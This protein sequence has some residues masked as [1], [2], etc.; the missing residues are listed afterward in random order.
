MVH[1]AAHTA[2]Q[3]LPPAEPRVSVDVAQ[4]QQQH[5]AEVM[6]INASRASLERE[7]AE[8]RR[9]AVS[10]QAALGDAHEACEGY[11]ELKQQAAELARL[12]AD[13]GAVE[14]DLHDT[15][16]RLADAQTQCT[17]MRAEARRRGEREEALTE[18]LRRCKDEAT[19]LRSALEVA[20]STRAR[21][22]AAAAADAVGARQALEQA[23]EA[24]RDSMRRLQ[25]ERTAAASRAKQATAERA[26]LC[27]RVSRAEAAALLAQAGPE[28]PHSLT[29]LA[30]DASQAV[31]CF[32]RE[33]GGEHLVWAC[34]SMRVYEH[35]GYWKVGK[36]DKMAAGTGFLRSSTKASESLPH[37]AEWQRF[38]PGKG[39]WVASTTRVHAVW[40]EADTACAAEA[41]RLL[42]RAIDGSQELKARVAALSAAVPAR[43]LHAR[44]RDAVR[45]ESGLHAGGIQAERGPAVNSLCKNFIDAVSS[46]R[47]DVVELECAYLRFLQAAKEDAPAPAPAVPADTAGIVCSGGAAAAA[48]VAEVRR[49]ESLETLETSLSSD[50]GY[51]SDEEGG[52]GEEDADSSEN[53]GATM[54]TAISELRA[55]LPGAMSELHFYENPLPMD[56]PTVTQYSAP[57]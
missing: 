54:R 51:R 40:H 2:A 49:E 13:K 6:Q 15:R 34:G 11:E 16:R 38:A 30:F 46:G 10:L 48:A 22:E 32:A 44:L 7:L 12:A 4:Q 1:L 36:A 29:V 33:E 41:V 42:V 37:A 31:G 43:T 45:Q 17:E 8:A 5:R 28:V 26:A 53:L 57:L 24:R 55:I 19:G 20:G 21:V 25:A 18:E 27:V 52:G 14:H 9:E 3:P 39:V 35:G 23:E 50:D 47:F 56:F